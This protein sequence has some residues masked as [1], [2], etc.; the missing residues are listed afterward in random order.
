M[1]PPGI[2]HLTSAPG[3]LQHKHITVQVIPQEQILLWPI[4]SYQ[5]EHFGIE[6]T[7]PYCHG[8]YMDTEHNPGARVECF[9]VVGDRH[10]WTTDIC[11]RSCLA[12]Y[13]LATTINVYMNQCGDITL[14]RR[15]VLTEQLASKS[16]ISVSKIENNKLI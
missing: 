16:E 2:I 13:G 11:C 4:L 10:W 3:E 15:C 7:C 5:H 12:S 1:K 14:V 9:H 8:Q 6:R